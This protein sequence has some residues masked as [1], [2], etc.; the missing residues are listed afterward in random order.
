[1]KAATTTLFVLLLA[2]FSAQAQTD[3]E[4]DRPDYSRDNLQ[5]VLSVQTEEPQT[6]RDVQYDIGAVSFRAL[7]TRWRFNY[8][9]IMMPLVGTRQTATWEWP[10]AF[11]LTN[12]PIA[13]PARAWRAS[14]QLSAERKRIERMTKA[15]VRVKTE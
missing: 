8:L 1:M 9:P 3:T 11:S 6:G 13:M 7:G 14:R 12:T 10:D 2:A 5:R 15:T 4:T